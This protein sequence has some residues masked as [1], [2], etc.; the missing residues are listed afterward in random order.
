M[1]DVKFM[2]K[3]ENIIT[4]KYKGDASSE[5]AAG[6]GEFFQNRLD[7]TAAIVAGVGK[8]NRIEY[9]IVGDNH[10]LSKLLYVLLKMAPPEVMKNLVKLE[11][12]QSINN[13]MNES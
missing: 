10:A 12:M 1:G 13:L 3:K 2:A 4:P 5:T 8:E 11:A 7:L 9:S 6:I